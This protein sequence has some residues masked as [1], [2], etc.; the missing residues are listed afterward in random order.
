[1][2]SLKPVLKSF[3]GVISRFGNPDANGN[4]ILDLDLYNAH[5]EVSTF[6]FPM[7][8]SW[9]PTKRVSRFRAHRLEG[10]AIVDALREVPEKAGAAALK[11]RISNPLGPLARCKRGRGSPPGRHIAGRMMD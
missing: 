11:E 8:L 4:F 2:V 6:S 5:I 9:D 1:M 3:A 10:E 7:K